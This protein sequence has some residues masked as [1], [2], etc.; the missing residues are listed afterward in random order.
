MRACRSILLASSCI[1]S[2]AGGLVTRNLGHSHATVTAG[3]RRAALI[4]SSAVAIERPP[5]PT[6]V[7]AEPA[8]HPAFE[9]VRVEMVDEYTIKVATYRHKRSG[10][11][12]VSAQADD[13]NKV[14]R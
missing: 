11:E 8:T 1:A 9:L 3:T 2:A 12:V 14:S 10:A 6:V 7:S 5:L 4:H 13:E